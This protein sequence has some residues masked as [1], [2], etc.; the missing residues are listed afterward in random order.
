MQA[1]QRKQPPHGRSAADS[2]FKPPTPRRAGPELMQAGTENVD[3]PGRRAASQRTRH[4]ARMRE[5]AHRDEARGASARGETSDTGRWGARSLRAKKTTQRR[6]RARFALRCATFR[7][8]CRQRRSCGAPRRARRWLCPAAAVVKPSTEQQ[9]SPALPC[10]H[11]AKRFGTGEKEANSS[12]AIVFLEQN[13]CSV[14][15]TTVVFEHYFKYDGK[16]KK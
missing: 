16:P 13:Q 14:V 7:S 12:V 4:E 11:L 9:C 2:K 5:E 8:S 10:G 15:L 3:V 6:C 1:K